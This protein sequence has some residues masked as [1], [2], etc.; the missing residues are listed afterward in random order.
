MGGM[1]GGVIEE[2]GSP[3]EL[4]SALGL[5]TVVIGCAIVWVLLSRIGPLKSWQ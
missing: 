4:G 1:I 5:L 3:V 2:F